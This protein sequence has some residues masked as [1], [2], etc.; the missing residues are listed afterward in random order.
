MRMRTPTR[1]MILVMFA[2]AGCASH[3]HPPAPA[4]PTTRPIAGSPTIKPRA[5]TR[6]VAARSTTKPATL[7]VAQVASQPATQT[8]VEQPE[9]PAF[10]PAAPTTEPTEVETDAALAE[11]VAGLARLTVP[12]SVP[13]NDLWDPILRQQAA[14]LVAANKLDPTN[15]RIAR[16]LLEANLHLHDDDGIIAA[17][18]A[19]RR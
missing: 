17:F 5:T 12:M 4:K 3:K 7:P 1:A 19:I 2:V 8:A 16:L 14:M 18:D 6:P 10:N 11:R 13:S 9:A 15:A